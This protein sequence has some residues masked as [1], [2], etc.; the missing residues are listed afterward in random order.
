[1]LSWES[2]LIA[3]CW[4]MV[5]CLYNRVESYDEDQWRECVS[6]KDSFVDLKMCSRPMLGRDKG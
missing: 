3:K 5:D 1:M 6:L 2:Q 4:E